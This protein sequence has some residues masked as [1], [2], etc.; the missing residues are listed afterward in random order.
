MEPQMSDDL[1]LARAHAFHLAKT[2]MV[3]VT[4]FRSNDQFGVLPSHELDG[5]EVEMVVEF[6]PFSCWPA[7]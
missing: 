3:P 7:H 6:N 2:L 5:D 1:S 4:L